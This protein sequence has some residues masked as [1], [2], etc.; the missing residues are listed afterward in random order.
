MQY[1]LLTNNVN[2]I[3]AKAEADFHTVNALGMWDVTFYRDATKKNIIQSIGENLAPGTSVAIYDNSVNKIIYSVG[4]KDINL[5]MS[6]THILSMTSQKELQKEITLTSNFGNAINVLAAYDVFPR[7]NWNIVSFV[8]K[9]QIFKY[10]QQ[11][12]T[13]SIIIGG[14]LLIIILVIISVIS[15]RFS[16]AIVA[17]EEGA[18]QLSTDDKYHEI[19]LPGNDEFSKLAISFNRLA[20]DIRNKEQQL[21][22]SAD[23]EKKTNISL[24]ESRNLY[25][26]L[27]ENT[28]DVVTKVDLTGRIKFVNRAA[29]QM[30]GLS[31]EDC[32]GKMAFDFIHPDDQLAT[33]TAFAQWINNEENELV[34][35]NRQLGTNNKI[36]YIT[37]S[38]YREYDENDQFIGFASTG[39]DRTDYKISLLENTTLENQLIQSQKMEAVGELAGGVAHDFNNML[40]VILGHAQL[41]KKKSGPTSPC[42]SNLEGIIKA[43]SHSADLTKQLLTFARKENITPEIINLNSA[44]NSML[45]MLKRLIGE[46]IQLTFVQATNLW[47][48]KVDQAQI[49]QIFINLCVNARDAIKSLGEISISTKN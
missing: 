36:F 35:E 19:N 6:A 37:W 17:L 23:E 42:I 10:T 47:F 41:A 13:L 14:V 34:Y 38:I 43:A 25:H 44:I 9:E 1:E 31:A 29:A 27:I 22:L 11:A 48:I 4:D 24:L 46:N 26:D 33:R 45:D 3:I 21:K 28:P 7:L 2:N 32:I 16:R 15:R 5:L 30:F 39:V 49:N 20:T 18:Y 12:M 40:G 8:N